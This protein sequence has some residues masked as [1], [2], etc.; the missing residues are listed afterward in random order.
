MLYE[1]DAQKGNL[2]LGYSAREAT[3]LL[4]RL[5][6][7]VCHAQA[8]AHPGTSSSSS[9]AI[10]PG[11]ATSSSS[12]SSMCVPVYR[13]QAQH[14]VN[15]N[16]EEKLARAFAMMLGDAQPPTRDFTPAYDQG[17]GSGGNYNSGGSPTASVGC[18]GRMG[19][20]FGGHQGNSS[21]NQHAGGGWRS[22]WGG[23][24]AFGIFGG[25]KRQDQRKLVREVQRMMGGGLRGDD[26]IVDCMLYF[27]S[28]GHRV[29]LVTNDRLLRLRAT[30]EGVSIADIK[31]WRGVVAGAAV[32]GSLWG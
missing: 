9:S 14:E 10:S 15:Q 20:W 7:M 11:I 5:Q 21:S 26:G 3:K 18:M 4:E 12:S 22:G 30:T 1:L 19:S 31:E 6:K 13:G 8:A 24:R 2:L 29:T 23:D 28:K 25:L 27:Q 32:G 16:N 17:G